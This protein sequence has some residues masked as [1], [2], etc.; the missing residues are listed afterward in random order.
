M[1]QPELV[2]PAGVRH[3]QLRDPKDGS[4]DATKR[5][6]QMAFMAHGS[7]ARFGYWQWGKDVAGGDHEVS[8]EARGGEG[9]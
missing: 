5:I 1:L 6:V 2:G 7:L 9:S 8:G 3:Q 4:G